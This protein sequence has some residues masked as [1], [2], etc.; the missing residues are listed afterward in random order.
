[1]QLAN[2]TKP[3]LHSDTDKNLLS[4]S[5]L[6]PILIPIASPC[7]IP[8]SIK[9]VNLLDKVDCWIRLAAFDGSDAYTAAI[10]TS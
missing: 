6:S 10:S 5:S 1:M 3:A 8:F 9:D 4:P 7:P 2:K